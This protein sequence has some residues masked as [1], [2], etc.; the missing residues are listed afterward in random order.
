LDSYSAKN[1]PGKFEVGG[2]YLEIIEFSLVRNLPDGEVVEGLYG[3]NVAK[4]R[5]VV[6]LPKINKLGSS[7]EGVAGI[8]ELR[9]VPIPA[10]DLC[11]I[12][13]DKTK[14]EY[15]KSQQIIVTEFSQKRA[16]FIVETTHR[17]RRVAW[18]KVLPTSAEGGHCMSGMILIENKEFMF[19]LDLER[20]LTNIENVDAVNTGTPVR[21]VQVM[22]ND[23]RY[24]PMD[25]SKPGILLV[26]DS[27]L[28]LNNVSNIFKQSGFRVVVADNGY[29]AM[30]KL[31]EIA[32]GDSGF[33][34][35]NL[36]VTDVEMPRMDGL[37]FIKKIRKN[38]DFAHIPIIL[39]TS[40]SGKASRQE[41]QVVGA[42]GYVVKNDLNNLLSL[43]REY[44]QEIPFSIGA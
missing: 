28:V 37:S 38:I 9:G 19:I 10:I 32:Y 27:R 41:A 34:P 29:T 1:Y 16:G 14:P 20:I 15:R 7:I 36:I 25:H 11:S 30:E 17:I 24:R 26:D 35:L 18:D 33:G 42:N 12:L 40:L 22:N 2:N 4:V 3:V 31:E 6:H 13:G 44:L 39:H 21:N 8:F 43:V 23:S 5:E